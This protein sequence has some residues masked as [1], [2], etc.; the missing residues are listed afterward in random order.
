ML[1]IK[2]IYSSFAVQTAIWLLKPWA[3]LSYGWRG[4]DAGPVL[5]KQ[6]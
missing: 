3:K 6:S 5:W 2:D 1:V 4:N